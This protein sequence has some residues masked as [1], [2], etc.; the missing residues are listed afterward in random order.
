MT[1]AAR[2]NPAWYLATPEWILERRRPTEDEWERP[3]CVAK[4]AYEK[5]LDQK[6]S[7]P[8]WAKEIVQVQWNPIYGRTTDA[9]LTIVGQEA[10]LDRLMNNL[11]TA[12]VLPLPPMEELLALRNE[13]DPAGRPEVPLAA[14]AAPPQLSPSQ[15]A[16][17]GLRT[18]PRHHRLHHRLRHRRRRRAR[19]DRRRRRCSQA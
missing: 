14:L 13:E 12:F 11:G 10:D 9:R 17:G 5:E 16:T 3:R 6:R 18:Q 2:Q 4:R 15:E 7:P 19:A 1:V 8:E